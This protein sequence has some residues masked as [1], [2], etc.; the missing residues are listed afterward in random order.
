MTE[1][2]PNKDSAWNKARVIELY[3]SIYNQHDTNI[4]ADYFEVDYLEHN[5]ELGNGL[6]GLQPF[7][8]KVFGF[9]PTIHFTLV[10]LVAEDNLVVAHTLMR[11]TPDD[12]GMAI[13]EIF[14]FSEGKI[15][16]RWDVVAP[17]PEETR[18]GNPMV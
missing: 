17:V 14:R 8:K 13:A 11:R 2:I 7:L 10:R 16:E 1:V 9:C 18:N 4:L 12:R 3:D 5:P 15:A 6:A